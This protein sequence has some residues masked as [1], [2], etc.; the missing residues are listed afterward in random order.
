MEEGRAKISRASKITNG[1]GE[2]AG[3]VLSVKGIIDLAVQSVPSRL[4]T[5]LSISAPSHPTEGCPEAGLL[6]VTDE[7]KQDI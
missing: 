4:A 7:G 3:F 6:Y 2:V 1:V 5:G